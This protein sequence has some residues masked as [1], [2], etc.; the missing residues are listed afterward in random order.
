MDE[1]VEH[2][3]RELW[4]RFIDPTWHTVRNQADPDGNVVLPTPEE[5]RADKPNA[6]SWDISV[7]DGAMFGGMYLEAAV[8]RWQITNQ[9]EDRENAR[10]IASGLMKLATVGQTKGFIARGL[11][12]DGSA[13]YAGSSNDQTLP[14]LYGMWRYV[15]SEV[16]DEPEREIVRAKIIEVIE[17]LRS[18]GWRV[19]CDRPPFDYFGTFAG[20]DWHSAPR[21]LF[22]L[23][24]AADVSGD[25]AWE[26]RYRQALAEGAPPGKANR[27]DTCA[28]G[29]VSAL[30]THHT[31]TAC[32]GAAGLRGLWE[33]ER[34]PTLKA[35]YEQGLRASARTA[36]ESLPLALE[37][38]NSDR[39]TFLLDWRELN[40][41]WHEQHSVREAREL[42][43]KQL[44][45]LDSLSPRRG[46]EVRLVRE[47]LF[48]AWVVTLC[49]D[50]EIVRRHAPAI[51]AAI[52]HYRYDGLY[53]SQF[54]PAELAYY[55]L[56]LSGIV[57]E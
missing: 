2:A 44:R 16:P 36:A 6:L 4:R 57:L 41:L 8:Y 27:L 12:P 43:E 55:R 9:A 17:A 49:P 11:P 33:L 13:H 19:P 3:H 46:Y 14:W 21:L 31:W 26:E 48:A 30:Q 1:A 51:L 40:T 50:P 7:T 29:M 38:D 37:F 42:A 32:P 34:D 54:F 20:F 10:R 18:H 24:M 47:P 45:L 23:K 28:K 15:R 56:R 35:A 52:R 39:Q 25:G 22:L 5:C 53:L